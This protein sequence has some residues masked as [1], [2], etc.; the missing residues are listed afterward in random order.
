MLL[1]AGAVIAH[2]AGNA[3]GTKLR[4]AGTATGQ[5]N[6]RPM[7]RPK[8]HQFAPRSRLSDH[9]RLSWWMWSS[10]IISALVAGIGGGSA[11]AQ[12]VGDKATVG[13]V[14]LAVVSS[15]ILGGLIGFWVSSFMHIFIDALRQA[16]RDADPH[17]SYVRRVDSTKRD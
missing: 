9:R 8:P 15:A 16:H 7:Q 4:A 2:I 17:P 1:F 12:T 14:S 13:N 10:C 5:T 11:L 3:I 6:R